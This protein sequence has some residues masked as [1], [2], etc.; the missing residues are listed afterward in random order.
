MSKQLHT[1]EENVIFYV[2]NV[3]EDL[4]PVCKDNGPETESVYS[5]KFAVL[6]KLTQ[7]H[8]PETPTFTCFKHSDLIITCA[9]NKSCISDVVYSHSVKKAYF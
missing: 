6:G 9:D 2:A 1:L 4:A 3:S 5:N 7:A 8:F